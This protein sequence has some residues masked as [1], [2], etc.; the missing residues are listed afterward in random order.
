MRSN[1][2]CNEAFISCPYFIGETGT[3]I[4]CEG[5]EDKTNVITKFQSKPDKQTFL[6]TRCFNIDSP[7]KL[8]AMLN[9]KLC[10]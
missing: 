2:T 7:C 8:G 6:R 1:H 3:T 9:D 10:H 5:I 4:T